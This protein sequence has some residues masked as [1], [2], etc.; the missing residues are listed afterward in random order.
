VSLKEILAAL[1]VMPESDR[2]AVIEDAMLATKGMRWVPNPGPQEQAYFSEADV[3]L[4]GGEPG[5][6]KS[7]LILGLAFNCHR[8]SLIMRRKYSDLGRIVEDALKINGGREGFNGS[9]PPKLRISANQQ[10]D[11]GAA[12]RVGDEQDWMGKGRDFLGIDEATHFAE[13]QIRFLMGW[14]RTEHKGQR[15]RTVLATNPPLSAEGLWVVSM[16]AP[17]L[18]PTFHNPAKPGELRWVI[19]NE[20]GVDQWVDGPEPVVI[21]G[22]EYRPMSRTYIPASVDDNPEYADSDYKRQLE[23]MPEPFRSLLMGGFKTSFQDAPNQVI[24][25]AW[26]TAAQARWSSSPPEGIPMCSMGVDATGG[27]NDPMTIACRHDGW[28]APIVKIP[29]KELPIEKAGRMAAGIVVS[30]RRDKAKVII[31]LGGG[32]GLSAYEQLKA[33]DVDVIG[34]RGAEKSERRTKDGSLKFFNKRSETIWR[35]REALD[36]GQ[37]GGSTIALPPSATLTA[38]LTAPTLDMS[39]NG[40]KVESKEDV[41]DRLGRS[42]DDGDAVV[43]AWTAGAKASEARD[44]DIRTARARTPKVIQGHQAARRR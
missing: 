27:G 28:Y 4:Y 7:Q 33:N 5:G 39:F 14:N 6:G 20:E 11:F 3:L 17:W 24:P 29:A 30:H 25:T 18:D 9:P 22:K 13:S 12:H 19:S 34:Y 35:F 37:P 40:I 26:V 31:D 41:C 1:E 44:G 43:M 23:A 38:D 10:I 36:P 15:V 32:F 16:F 42:T 21:D 2:Q 8:R